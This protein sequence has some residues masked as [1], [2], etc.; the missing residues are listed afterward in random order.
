MNNAFS[1]AGGEEL[2]SIGTSWFVFYFYY[3]EIDKNHK[4]WKKVF[5]YQNRISTFNNTNNYHKSWLTEICNMEE[6]RLEKNTI[7]LSG[8]EVQ[9]MAEKILAKIGE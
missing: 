2:S 5:T 8:F 4:N 6:S 1:F 3:L 7:G 9:D